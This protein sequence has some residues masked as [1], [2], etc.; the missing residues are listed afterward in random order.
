MKDF[1]IAMYLPSGCGS[2]FCGTIYCR[3]GMGR[4]MSSVTGLASDLAHPIQ[5]LLPYPPYSIDWGLDN[6]ARR[7]VGEQTGRDSAPGLARNIGFSFLAPYPLY[8]G[9]KRCK[10]L[11]HTRQF[12]Q[13]GIIGIISPSKAS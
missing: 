3:A 11:I 13:C 2:I 12:R 7:R 9:E 6:H 8:S 5:H 1:G 4:K 10:T